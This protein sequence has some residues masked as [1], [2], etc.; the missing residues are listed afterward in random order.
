LTEAIMTRLAAEAGW[1]DASQ[2]ALCLQYISNQQDDSAFEDFLQQQLDDAQAFSRDSDEPPPP[3]TPASPLPEIPPLVNY[4]LVVC[5]NDIEMELR[6]PF[7]TEDL[8]DQAA[9]DHRRENDGLHWLDIVDGVPSAGD[10]SGGFFDAA[11]EDHA[12]E[13]KE[14][15]E[16][17]DYI[18]DMMAADEL[19]DEQAAERM[20][21]EE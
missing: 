15:A 12:D 16:Y 11:S 18:N 9:L 6:G 3:V 14:E 1:N 17:D 5:V 2:L 13:L 20:E 7:D 19:A 10:Y 21:D 8:R 4:W